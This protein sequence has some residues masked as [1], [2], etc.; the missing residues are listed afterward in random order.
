MI[1][2]EIQLA[3]FLHFLG[4][5]LS[6]EKIK[7]SE[8]Y[9]V[10]RVIPQLLE[11]GNSSHN[12][13]S[14][15]IDELLIENKIMDKIICYYIEYPF[16]NVVHSFVTNLLVTIF[17][18]YH[19]DLQ[20]HLIKH[21]GHVNLQEFIINNFNNNTLLPF[22]T[23]VAKTIN[24]MC[25]YRKAFEHFIFDFEPWRKFS[26][27]LKNNDLDH[28]KQR[29]LI[30]LQTQLKQNRTNLLLQHKMIENEE[31]KGMPECYL[32]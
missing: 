13:F 19:F 29:E 17:Q 10:A 27:N 30:L 23:M 12:A 6:D 26:E 32:F 1:E 2:M 8:K 24:H 4:K 3:F 16:N 18:Y 15:K 22:L 9:K 11:F 5:V 25:S 31:W 21:L 28:E 7:L 20:I 14:K